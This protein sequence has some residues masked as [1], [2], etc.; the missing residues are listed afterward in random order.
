MTSI[1]TY[2]GNLRTEATHLQSGS[3][4]TTDAP[5][6]NAGKGEAF[7]PT[8]LVATALGSCMVTIMG[9]LAN[10]EG[11][12][13]KEISFEI[14]KVMDS[15]PRRISRIEIEIDMKTNFNSHEKRRLENAAIN[16]PVAKSLHPEIEQIINFI[17]PE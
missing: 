3:K 1:V 12:D 10:N 5:K 16:C 11:I 14:V 4:I 2:K 8:D 15:N 13:L 17:Y 6:D 9:I 7:S